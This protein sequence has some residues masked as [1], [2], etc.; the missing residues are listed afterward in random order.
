MPS[1]PCMLLGIYFT[2]F[3]FERLVEGAENKFSLPRRG[4]EEG[5]QFSAIRVELCFCSSF[6]L[7]SSWFARSFFTMALGPHLFSISGRVFWDSWLSNHLF[8]SALCFCC[9]CFVEPFFYSFSNLNNT[10]TGYSILRGNLDP[11]LQMAEVSELPRKQ[12]AIPLRVPMSIAY[13]HGRCL[14]G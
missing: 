8:R 6:F 3:V 2:S 10:I 13:Y 1:E 14:P 4:D 5:K 9:V 7:R 12:H 11:K